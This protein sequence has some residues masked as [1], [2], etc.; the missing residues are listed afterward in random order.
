MPYTNAE[1]IAG[2]RDTNTLYA[3]V[4]DSD[5]RAIARIEADDTEEFTV[6]LIIQDLNIPCSSITM[7][8][9]GSLLVVSNQYKRKPV[10]RIF[11]INGT[12]TKEVEL[13]IKCFD[14]IRIDSLISKSNG[15]FVLTAST[16]K[17]GRL[18][19][20]DSNGNLI[21]MNKQSIAVGTTATLADTHGRIIMS[22][23]NCDVTLLDADFNALEIGGQRFPGT[24]YSIPSTIKSDPNDH[25]LFTLAS[26]NGI[27]TD[28][29]MVR[30]RITEN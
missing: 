2:S 16:D 29:I 3:L 14:F 15:H 23:H 8:A 12:M 5:R 6:G 21:R 7:S 30:F 4:K 9:S 20:L 24:R 1:A 27:M 17:F 18:I 25:E 11:D 10:F 28:S 22:N 19:E 26:L 13:C